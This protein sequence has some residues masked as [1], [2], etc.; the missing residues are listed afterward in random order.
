MLHWKI[1][2]KYWR[3]KELQDLTVI[4]AVKKILKM[5]ARNDR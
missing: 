4:E 3:D 1:Y 5:E 2:I